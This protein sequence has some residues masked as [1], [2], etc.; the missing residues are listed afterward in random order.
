M[1]ILKFRYRMILDFSESATGHQFTL[2][3][4]PKSDA[5]QQVISCGVKLEPEC[6]CL[7]GEDAFGNQY[8]Y[9]EITQEHTRFC[10]EVFG[11]AVVEN[12]GIPVRKK[13]ES[14]RFRYPSRYTKAGDG[15]K[16]YFIEFQGKCMKKGY[17]FVEELMHRL[18]QDMEYRQGVTDIST[19]AEEAIC[20]RQGVCQDY[21]HIMIALCRLGGI[22]ARYV[23]GMMSG[24]GYSHAWAEVCWDGIW[25]GMDPTNDRMVDDGY[26]KISHGRDYQDCIVNRGVFLGGGEQRQTVAVVVEDADVE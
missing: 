10:V 11:R 13:T 1:R 24:E 16:N 5:R 15:L 22:A 21:A 6:A 7:E 26:V 25:Y 19:T 4:L 9:G 20:Q 14:D 12:R 3:M 18:Y 23:V 8:L 17:A 2:R